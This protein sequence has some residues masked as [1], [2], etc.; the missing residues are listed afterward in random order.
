MWALAA[1]FV[2][3]LALLVF[4]ALLAGA[5]AAASAGPGF[6]P[7]QVN[8]W[9]PAIQGGGR[10]LLGG[11]ALAGAAGLIFAAAR[12][13]LAEP[14][15]LAHGR[16]QVLSTWALSRGAVAAILIGNAVIAAPPAALFLFAP[17]GPLWRGLQGLVLAALWLPMD[18]GLMAYVFANRAAQKAGPMKPQ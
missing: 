11:L 14:A 5:Y 12:I 17:A 10:W 18:V 2:G 3:V 4:V 13:S 9:A 8:T 16:V 15:S 6:D 1:L 7:A